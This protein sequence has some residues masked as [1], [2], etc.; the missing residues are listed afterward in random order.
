MPLWTRVFNLALSAALLVGSQDA[1]AQ[2][3]LRGQ[4]LLSAEAFTGASETELTFAFEPRLRIGLRDGSSMTLMPTG[5]IDLRGD[6]R[7]VLD[8]VRLEWTKSWDEWELMLGS[9]TDSWGVMESYRAVDIINQRMPT[10]NSESVA[11]LA[12][13][14]ARMTVIKPWGTV[15]AYV[16]P[17]FRKRP[18]VGR[19]GTLWTDALVDDD[20]SI[21]ADRNG[22][23]PIDWAARWSHELSVLEVAVSHFAGRSRDAIFTTDGESENPSFLPNYELTNQT[24]L[25]AQWTAGRL[26]LKGEALTRKWQN[27]RIG[28]F[29]AGAEYVVADYLSLFAEYLADTRG[30]DAPSSFQNDVFVGVRAVFDGGSLTAG[31]FVDTDSGNRLGRFNVLRSLTDRFAIRLGATG[32]GGASQAEPQH[33]LRHE[34][35][36]SVGLVAFF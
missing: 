35:L 8:P 9:S 3:Q 27:D 16:L 18:F 4:A 19:A 10:A 21:L 34:T 20:R 25:E 12:Q 2:A 6:G 31:L 26:L 17:G 14:M 33:A 32:F 28:V 5:W 15:S 30:S 7:T 11:K 29:A 24:S 1:S 13:P 23:L 36:L 22:L